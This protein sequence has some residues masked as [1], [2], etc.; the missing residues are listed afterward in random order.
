MNFSTFFG[1]DSTD[2][3]SLGDISRIR[4]S[5]CFV[6]TKQASLGDTA[7]IRC[8]NVLLLEPV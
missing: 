3:V 2:A 8:P 5:F 6:D 4:L 1:A 7:V